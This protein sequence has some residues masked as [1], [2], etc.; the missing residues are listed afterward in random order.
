MVL[1]R[2]WQWVCFNL[3]VTCL[4]AVMLV[5]CSRLG[6]DGGGGSNPIVYKV[7]QQVPEGGGSYKVGD[8]YTVAGQRYYPREDL[9][10]DK[11][12]TAS[13]YGEYFHGRKTA[14]GEWYDM[15]RLSAAHPT[16]PLPVYVRVTHLD[17]G[18]SLVVR[19]NDRGPFKRE[20]II[21]LSKRAAEQLGMLTQGTASVRVEYLA[22]A[23]LEG[24]VADMQSLVRATPWLEPTVTSSLK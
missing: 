15:N 12:G 16:L 11:I 3:G 19:V 13:W 24:D 4:C 1:C 5:G 20:R 6:S 23:P 10:Y 17:N 18:R 9:H 22:L 14:N 2:S 8:S 7:Y 21:D